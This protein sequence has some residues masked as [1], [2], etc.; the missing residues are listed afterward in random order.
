MKHVA[1]SKTEIETEVERYICNP[2]Q[3]LCYKIG[4]RKISHLKYRY[5]KKFGDTIESVR[6]FH[7]LILE[8]GVLPLTILERKIMKM[9]RS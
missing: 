2:A 8:D 6:K 9:I 3:A 1:L 5:L 4:E 7:E